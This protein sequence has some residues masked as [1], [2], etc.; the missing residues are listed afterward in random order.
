VRILPTRHRAT[1]LASDERYLQI[2]LTERSASCIM[3]SMAYL[4]RGDGTTT[5]IAPALGRVFR[6]QEIYDLLRSERVQVVVLPTGLL[7]RPL[8]QVG[9]LLLVDPG[10]IA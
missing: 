8:G 1:I 3:F 4:I 5:V 9:D 7:L 6:L 10:V 2:A